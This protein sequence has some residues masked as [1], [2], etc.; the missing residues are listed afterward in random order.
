[1]ITMKYFNFPKEWINSRNIP[2]EALYK[3][4]EAD[5]KLKKLFVDNVERIRLEYLVTPKNSNI[6]SYIEGNEKYEEIHFYTIEFKRKGSEEKIAKLLHEI[7]PKATVIEIKSDNDWKISTAIK[8]IGSVSLKIEKIET[9]D[10][11]SEDKDVQFIKS[12]N[13]KNFNAMNLKT[14]YESITDRV[15]ANK[16]LKTIGIFSIENVSENNERT[17]KIL[18]IQNQIN[19]W[20]KELKIEKHSFKR[21]EI[22]KKIKELNK[23]LE[24]NL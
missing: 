8:G 24:E 10:W 5:E 20:K 3:V 18:D 22:V 6:Q 23:K 4:L 16:I 11:L 19:Y 12:L 15:K 17:E 13:A 7:V 1:M 14:F 21:A 2:K 9:T